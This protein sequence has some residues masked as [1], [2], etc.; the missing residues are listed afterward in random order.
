MKQS[1][2]RLRPRVSAPRRGR[3]PWQHADYEI[4]DVRAI[5]SLAIFAQAAVMPYPPGEEPQFTPAQ[6]KQVLDCL[7]RMTGGYG[8]TF[9]PGQPDVSDYLQGRR[10]IWLQVVKLMKLK[11]A[12]LEKD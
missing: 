4:A 6:A 2:M 11:P 5:Q 1:P 7:E 3:K 8:E 9:V 12:L 10:S